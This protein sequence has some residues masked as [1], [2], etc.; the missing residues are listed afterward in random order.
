FHSP[1]II[2]TSI[3]YN[4]ITIANVATDPKFFLFII[5]LFFF[6]ILPTFFNNFDGIVSTNLFAFFTTITSFF[7]SDIDKTAMPITNQL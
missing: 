4:A 6:L 1:I 5:I 7:M 2:N 3:R